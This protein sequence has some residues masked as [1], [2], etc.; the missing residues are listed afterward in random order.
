MSCPL[1]P[2]LLQTF[3]L[4]N[5]NTTHAES[6]EFDIKGGRL[7][8]KIEQRKAKNRIILWPYSCTASS[9]F[10]SIQHPRQLV[11]FDI[12]PSLSISDS[13]IVE[14]SDSPP[15]GFNYSTFLET[16]AHC[17]SAFDELLLSKNNFRHSINTSSTSTCK[18]TRT[19]TFFIACLCPLCRTPALRHFIRVSRRLSHKTKETLSLNM[20]CLCHVSRK[21]G[22]LFTP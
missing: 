19:N 5:G 14:Q 17:L 20:S 12:L 10:I 21:T 2:V 9:Q 1:R 6:L 18:Q 4:R 13:L 7:S 3:H 11:S 16:F 22:K 15:V 8:G